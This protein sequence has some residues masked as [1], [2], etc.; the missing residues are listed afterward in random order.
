MNA[1]APINM[2]TNE[3]S[4]EAFRRDLPDFNLG[5]TRGPSFM[6]NDPNALRAPQLIQQKSSND[7]LLSSKE[8]NNYR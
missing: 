8:M 4:E 6:E 7:F 5:L 1:P 3:P 2:M